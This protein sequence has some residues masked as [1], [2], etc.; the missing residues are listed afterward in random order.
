MKKFILSTAVVLGAVVSGSAMAEVAD[1]TAPWSNGNI[2][3]GPAAC[4]MLADTVNLGTSANVHGNYSCDEVLNV[5]KVGTCHKGGSR[6]GVTCST[7]DADNDP[8]TAPTLVPSA[9]CT[10]ELAQVS[11]TSPTPAYSAFTASSSG[12]SMAQRA[13]DGRCDNTTLTGLAFW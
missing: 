11:A 4:P 7:E 5:I 3:V 12:G 2:A 10:L 8:S 9:G 6:K 1:N 13:L